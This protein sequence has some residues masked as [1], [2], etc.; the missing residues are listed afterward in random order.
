MEGEFIKFGKN[1]VSKEELLSSGHRACQGCGLAINIRLALKVLG[2]DTICF[3]P[4]SC[5]SGVGS[6]YP[7]AAW[8]VP[9]MQ[10]L[11]ENVSPVA[12]G[13][14][15]AHRILEEKGKRAVRKV[16]CVCFAG[17]GATADIG[18]GSLSGTLER[19]HNIIYVC[20][21]NEAY[22][23]TGIQ[24]SSSTPHGA[25]TT[26]TPVGSVIQG[27]QTYKKDVPAIVADHNIPYVATACVSYP[28]DYM[29]KIRKAAE[30]DGPAYIHV[31]SVCPT[32][33]RSAPD[34]SVEIGKLAVETGVF[35]LW[36]LENGTYK[37]NVN[38]AKLK[39]VAD[40]VKPQGRFR[41]LTASDIEEMQKLVDKNWAAL[42]VK[43]EASQA[44]AQ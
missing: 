20:L 3:T 19:G 38:P 29:A 2:K 17:D 35:P 31:Y 42:K 18:L 34:L 30:V 23:N 16:N 22:M 33:W 44:K 15:A 39:P 43:V 4:A 1:L 40:Y 37:L 13:V 12:G 27:Q 8:E 6:A 25:S 26:T 5:W 14:E 41:H 36:E 24:R 7:D 21:D 10:T 11:F 32:G 28:F 9:W